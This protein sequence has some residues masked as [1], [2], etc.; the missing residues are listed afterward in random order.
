MHGIERKLHL[1]TICIYS[2]SSGVIEQVSRKFGF[3]NAPIFV[4]C[5]TGLAHGLS[6]KQI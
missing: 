6:F 1:A 3:S 2:V 5:H 4:P